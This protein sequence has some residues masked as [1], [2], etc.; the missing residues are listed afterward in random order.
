MMIRMRKMN[1]MINEVM[2]VQVNYSIRMTLMVEK[3]AV[4]VEKLYS[5]FLLLLL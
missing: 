1:E 2:I 3:L 5:Y 4:K